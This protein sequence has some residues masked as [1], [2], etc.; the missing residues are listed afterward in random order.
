[1]WL[2][3]LC[4]PPPPNVAALRSRPEKCC[5]TKESINRASTPNSLHNYNK[6]IN[7]PRSEFRITHSISKMENGVMTNGTGH[8]SRPRTPSINAFSLTEY[9]TNPSPPS[10]TPKP[11]VS[12]VVP[13][14]FLLPNGTPDVLP[15]SR[16][17]WLFLIHFTVPTPYSHQPRLRSRQGNA[18]HSCN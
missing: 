4:P 17:Q 14:E 16:L 2:Q 6:D 13:E 9:S 7:H 8:E 10:T 12:S 3:W 18:P 5:P 15:Q 11:K 1:M